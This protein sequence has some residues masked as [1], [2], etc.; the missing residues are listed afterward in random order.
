MDTAIPGTTESER[1]PETATCEHWHEADRR[2][3]EMTRL[4]VAKIDADPSLVQVGVENMKRCR[5]QRGGYQ[6]ACLD[7]WEDLIA[8]EP[9]QKLRERLLEESDEGQ[10]LISPQQMHGLHVA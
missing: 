8:T 4:T 10:R 3:L 6:P 5:R 2:A 7:E 9:W 1:R